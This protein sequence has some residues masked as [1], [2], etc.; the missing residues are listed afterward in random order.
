MNKLSC[1]LN[2]RQN[3]ENPEYGKLS[4]TSIFKEMLE[5]FL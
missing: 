1:Q 4:S 3:C 5:R 2:L